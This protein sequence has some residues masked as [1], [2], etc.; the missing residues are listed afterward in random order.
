MV[1]HAMPVVG[2]GDDP[3]LFERADGRQFFPRDILGDGARHK[4][5]DLALPFRALVDQRHRPGIV[6]GR[7]SVGHAN[8]RGESAARRR[9]RAG[10]DGFLGRLPRFPQM[11]VQIN[12]AGAN[13]HAVGGKPGRPRR[14]LRGGGGADGGDFSIQ[15]QQ[16]RHGIEAIGRVNHAA[17]RDEERIWQIHR[18]GLW[19]R[20]IDNASAAIKMEG[21]MGAGV[22]QWQSSS[23]PS[24]S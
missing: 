14:G 15:N 7:R 8:H 21:E 16:V 1:L 4:H 10:G 6:N 5:I 19:R 20:G 3:R 11:R 9:R 24:W 22:A 17:A 2:D 18:G 23:L 13:H 12:Q